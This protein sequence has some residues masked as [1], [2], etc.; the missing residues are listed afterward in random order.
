[1]IIDSPEHFFICK[2]TAIAICG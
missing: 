2:H 1:L